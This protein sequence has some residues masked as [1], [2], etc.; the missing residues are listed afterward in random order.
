MNLSFFIE[1]WDIMR[2][3]SVEFLTLSMIILQGGTKKTLW[4]VQLAMKPKVTG[5]AHHN[6]H[7]VPNKKWFRF[8]G[9]DRTL[10]RVN[11]DPFLYPK[12]KRESLN[13]RH[14]FHDFLSLFLSSPPLLFFS[15]SPSSTRVSLFFANIQWLKLSKATITPLMVI[16]RDW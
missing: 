7:L 6:T 9:T 12:Y 15:L 13:S 1:E 14:F 10:H 8:C 5:P 16:T 3:E 4:E 2:G 11:T